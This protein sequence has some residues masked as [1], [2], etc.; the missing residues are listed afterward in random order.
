[1]GQTVPLADL[2]LSLKAV[3]QRQPLLVPDT[4]QEPLFKPVFRGSEL[5]HCLLLLP[6]I[7]REEVTGLLGLISYTAHRYSTGD[8]ALAFRFA[9]QAVIAVD[10]ARL[11]E[12]V[13]GYSLELSQRVDQRTAEL[14][15]AQERL[16]RQEKLAVLGQMASG[17]AH[18]LRNPLG[19]ISNAVYFL[20]M[21]LAEAQPTVIDYLNIIANRVG[22]AEKIVSDLL[23]LSRTR[24]SEPQPVAVPGLVAEVLNRYPPP[25]NVVVAQELA[26]GLPPVF[27][28]PQQIGQVLANLVANAYQAMPTGGTLT[29]T[30]QLLPPNPQLPTPNS[31]LPSSIALTIADTGCGIPAKT[32][33]KIFEPL[34]TTKA[35]GIGLGLTV[36]KNLVE[37]NGGTINVASSE[38]QGS[39]FTITLPI[40]QTNS[41][42]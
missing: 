31:Q 34:F 11:Y 39:A 42:D 5:A 30:S 40:K 29:I 41:G 6:L 1:L 28:D 25:E 35:K 17:V 19:V 18:E 21:V 36:S 15:A 22:E 26:P 4:S 20:Q 27:V 8:T 9:Q 2:P 12:Q 32:R 14:I 16:T 33:Q 23:N 3:Q 38:G 7:S 24:P 37:V 13:R 10:N